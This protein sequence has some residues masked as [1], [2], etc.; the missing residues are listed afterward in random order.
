[1]E[2]FWQDIRYGVRTLYKNPAFTLIALVALTLGIGANTAIFSVVNTILL[3]PLAYNDPDQL[4]LINHNY[5]KIDLKASVSNP[6]YVYYREHAQSFSNVAAIDGWRVNLTG[7]GEPERLQG[8]KTSANLFPM[9]GIGAGIGRVFADEE[10]EIGRDH[11]V[12]LSD[13]FWR[14]R[15]S[16]DRD[17]VGKS[18]TLNGDSYT[19][20]GVMPPG[21]Q[22]GREVGRVID[23]WS[24]ISFA[25]QDLSFN[26]LT[27]EHLVVL[28][29]LKAGVTLKQ[30]QGEMDAIAANLRQQYMPGA[31]NSVWGLSLQSLNEL[32][33]G[34]I[35][36][37]LIVLLAAVV[38]VLLIACA[39]VANLVLARGAGRHKEV[40]VRTALGA[41]RVRIVRQLL[42]ESVLLAL[43]GGI[44]GLL[45]SMWGIGL[46]LKLGDNGIPRAYEIGLDWRVLGFTFGISVLTGILFGIIPAF[47]SSKVDLNDALKEGGRSGAS[48]LRRG[49]RNVLM[50]AEISLA[51]VLLVGAGLL[52]RSFFRLQQVN[53]GFQ[54]RNLLVMQLSL[55]RFKYS[56]VE[57][58]DQ[59]YQQ[60]L[61]ELRTLPGVQKA[62][63]VSVLPMSG[64]N[65]SG[66]FAIEGRQVAENESMP[67]GDRWTATSDYF[68][69]M[70]IPLIR[71]R[72]FTDHDRSDT[73]G[74]AII[75]EA[76]AQKYWPSE[77]PLGKR[78]SFEGGRANPKWREIV[79]IVGHVKHKGLE[80]ESRAQ[81][82][83]P[84][85]QR[86]TSD[87]FLV[88]RSSTEPSSL[89]G[90]V[91]ATIAARDKD[92]PVY[93]V[94]TM[95]QLVSDSLAQRRFAM[96]LLGVFA[97][98]ALVLAVVG[99]Y[100]V[101]S[102][103]VAQRTHEI[104]V[105]MA[106]GAQ[107]SD[108][109]KLVLGHGMVLVL[110]G[111]ALGLAGAF[112]LTRLMSALL[113]GVSATDPITFTGV[114]VILA[115]VALIA[116][117]VPARRAAKV[118]PMVALR[119]E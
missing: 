63:A 29:R 14:R 6:G 93:R 70:S 17:I 71:G 38:L 3:R 68:E 80:G 9:L 65:Q 42:T 77:D 69:T 57:Q 23:V 36:P 35:K 55:P 46:L 59:F 5:P 34:E 78:I 89:V 4:V 54:P 118:N 2:T 28:A 11:V 47:Q 72:L 88:V 10:N 58:Q 62:S 32:V 61:A 56:A 94:T 44:L 74:V 1:M 49:L 73:A 22:F 16:A 19:V 90:A 24:P 64:D 45:L 112:A 97:G 31:D 113:F 7:E 98:L 106:L 101:M 53:P 79:G 50:V 110:I 8:A 119:Y 67:H 51:I 39:N 13:S 95:D 60:L 91:R 108:V 83:Y 48:N 26:N 100:G 92:L 82:Y 114:S 43:I 99:I 105:R 75:D 15:Y 41:S 115:G 30:A 76:L 21:F 37:A 20:V 86:P 96:F 33:I 116:C 107:I 12:V 109:L 52:I 27:N 18:I 84:Y 85:S 66:S 25:P 102:Y 81:Y 111:V 104:G 40:A 103:M 87:M 117:L